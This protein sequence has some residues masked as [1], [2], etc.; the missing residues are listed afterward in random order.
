[1]TEYD[2]LERI[3]IRLQEDA[4][5]LHVDPVKDV[6]FFRLGEQNVLPSFVVYYA[7]DNG[8]LQRLTVRGNWRDA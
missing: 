7:N 1:M 6:P 3:R 4:D 2:A 8:E 5:F